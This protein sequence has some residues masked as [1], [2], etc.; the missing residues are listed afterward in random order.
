MLQADWEKSERE[1]ELENLK[2]DRKL[3]R[4]KMEFEERR[5]QLELKRLRLERETICYGVKGGEAYQQAV[6]VFG[7]ARFS[8]SL[9]LWTKKMT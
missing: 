7:G 2:L 6:L 9:I 1:L 5:M 4:E 3:E 8:T